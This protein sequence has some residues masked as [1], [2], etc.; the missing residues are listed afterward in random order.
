MGGL[1]KPF[2]E[3]IDALDKADA[4][5]HLRKLCRA[6]KVPI[7]EVIGD[8]HWP[9]VTAVRHE[10]WRWLHVEQGYSQRRIADWFGVDRTTI[11][12]AVQKP[13]Q[14]WSKKR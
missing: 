14:T 10:L 11:L 9:D 5:H 6:A 12:N 3:V 4:L 13:P 8:R 2:A 7:E 1:V